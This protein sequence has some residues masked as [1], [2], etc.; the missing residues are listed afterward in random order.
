MIDI[1]RSR[2]LYC[3]SRASIRFCEDVGVVLDLVGAL[4]CSD[5]YLLPEWSQGWEAADDD[6]E[7]ELNPGPSSC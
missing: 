7:R 2:P 5:A 6:A 1:D 3:P 4:L